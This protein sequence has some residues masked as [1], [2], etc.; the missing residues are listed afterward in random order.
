MR[1]MTS[2]AA[3]RRDPAPSRL[4]YRYE[5]LRLTPLYRGFI[6]FGLPVIAAFLVGLAVFSN[7]HVRDTI[8]MQMTELR[9][10]I[11]ERPEFMVHLMAVDGASDDLADDIREILP[12]DF[13]VTSFDLDLEAMRQEVAGLDTVASVSVR[14]RA[15]G[16]LQIDVTERTPAVVWRGPQGVETLDP[17]GH[18]VA[19]LMARAERPDLPL[20][21]GEGAD[22]AVPEA[23]TLYAE[24]APIAHRLRGLVRV[25]QRRW[26]VVLDRGVRIMLP[27]EGAAQALARVIALDSAQDL[28][29]RDITHIDLRLSQR[30]TVRL[31]PGAVTELRRIRQVERPNQ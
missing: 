9:R 24:A 22:Q 15:G 23:L 6:R 29:E 7:P 31:A 2:E 28:L 10:A 8:G 13:P 5:R 26:D 4:A 17:E 3:A 18:R 11:E 30:P 27:E 16:V 12:L 14:I 19:A 25:G 21:T 20:I 1:P